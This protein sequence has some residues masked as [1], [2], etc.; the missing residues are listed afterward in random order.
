MTASPWVRQLNAIPGPGPLI[1][2]FVT[3]SFLTLFDN[4]HA[5]LRAL[6]RTR[7]L[8]VAMDATAVDA[9]AARGVAVLRHG[10]DGSLGDFWAR[11]LPVF[12]AL[13]EGG[14]DFIHSDLDA[15]WLRDPIPMCWEQQTGD[16]VFSQGTFHPEAAFQHQGFVLC[17]G[18]FA[19]RAGPATAGFFHAVAA[20]A[21]RERDDQ[22]AINLILLEAGTIWD[23]GAQEGYRQDYAGR[24][25]T[26]F[27]QPLRGS[28]SPL[29]LEIVLLPHLWI[30]RL[31]M[32]TAETLVAHPVSPRPPADKPPVLAALGAWRDHPA[33]QRLIFT[34]HKSGTSLFDHVMRRLG[35]QLGLSVVVQYG[36]VAHIDPDADIVLLPHS[37]IG[38]LPVRR[39]RAIRML[40]DPRDLWVSGYLYHRRTDEGWCINTNF[41]LTAPITYPRVDFAC[42]HK[43][44][45]WKRAYLLG[46]GGRSYQQN[47]LD[48]DRE[49]G[50]A[51]ELAGYT[52]NTME[53]LRTWTWACP[54]ILDV[55]LE[56]L[57]GAYDATMAAIF[58]HLEL[59]AALL[60]LTV[61]EDVNRMDDAALAARPQIHA[62]E[63]SRF[64]AFLTPAQIAAFE[65]LHGD[66]IDRLGYPR[67]TG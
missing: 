43:P 9:L 29:G 16:L 14:I 58:R 67:A 51:F 55:R 49:S 40:R 15:V 66:V 32:R 42:Q 3:T 65:A 7:I 38:A 26:A 21:A 30:P 37:L 39:F 62:R 13:A 1:V 23:T 47:L 57:T 54:E 27:P 18:W 63:I 5:H 59:P 41:D 4:W 2:T 28:C 35:E 48:R 50:L 61:A 34:Y 44:E 11:R 17:C 52:A 56:A 20:R 45:L 31:A 8:A 19:V 25:F 24:G 33:P 36:R 6:G 53:A 12:A 46:L 22:T 10:F 64:R 60:P